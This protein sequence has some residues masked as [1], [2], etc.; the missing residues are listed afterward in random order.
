MKYPIAWKIIWSPEATP[1]LNHCWATF[2]LNSSKHL[3][4]FLDHQASPGVM[5][6]HHKF[7]NDITRVHTDSPRFVDLWQID[8]LSLSASTDSAIKI[9]LQ[10][11][12][13]PPAYPTSYLWVSVTLVVTTT[14]RFRKNATVLPNSSAMCL[15]LKYPGRVKG[16]I[17]YMWQIQF[18]INLQKNSYKLS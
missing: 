1:T 10:E 13:N 14:P 11:I 17:R 4:P 7:F 3:W 8:V 9:N 12:S 5:T 16:Q 15:F 2:V 6:C 18:V